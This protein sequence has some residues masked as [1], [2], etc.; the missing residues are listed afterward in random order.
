[1]SP[2]KRI[3][4]ATVVAAAFELIDHEGLAGLTM[5]ALG[6][7]VGVQAASLYHHVAGRDEL[8]KLVADSVAQTSLE[9]MPVVSDWR[10]SSRGL[11]DGLRSVLREHPGAAQIVA[12]QEVSPDVFEPALSIVEEV[13]IPC[14]DID[15][16]TALHLLQGLYVLVVGLA[17]AEAGNVPNPPAAPAGYYDAWFEVAVETYLDGVEARFSL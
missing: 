1:M 9:R 10:V 4:R 11:A 6:K 2:V 15:G 3:D 7:S 8:L 14:L 13:F 16:E 12:V 17:S 5:R